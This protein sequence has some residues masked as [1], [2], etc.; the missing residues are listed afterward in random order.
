MLM[1][2]RI[3]LG[4]VV[5]L[6]AATVVAAACS[7][8]STGPSGPTA[9]QT[10]EHIDSIYAAHL[11]AGTAS[12]SQFAYIIGVYLES[13]PAYG[14]TQTSF[15]VTTGTGT[16]KWNGFTIESE[17]EGD[18]IFINATYPVNGDL[19]NIF[20]SLAAYDSLGQV[21][22]LTALVYDSAGTY[23]EQDIDNAMLSNSASA[24]GAACSLQTGLA[25]DSLLGEV[26]EGATSCNLINNTY[27]A[28]AEFTATSAVPAGETSMSISNATLHGIRFGGTLIGPE[29][30]P[31]GPTIAAAR[32]HQLITSFRRR[33]SM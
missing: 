11:A 2:V 23:A 30:A 21:G 4:R 8:S 19:T 14:A 6:A 22:Q 17:D 10:A 18:S 28:S 16:Q 32:I 26:G 29:R 33:G 9:A 5:V 24:L 3:S 12:D 1:T 20:I 7:S 27:S 31:R 13:A 25:A 15:N